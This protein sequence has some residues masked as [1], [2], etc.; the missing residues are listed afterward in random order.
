MLQTSFPRTK[1]IQS[2]ATR[3]TP[4]LLLAVGFE[5]G[6]VQ[7]ITPA[8][9]ACLFV[10][11]AH[12]APVRAVLLVPEDGLV[13]GEGVANTGFSLVTGSADGLVKVWRGEP[14][15]VTVCQ[16]HSAQVRC[17]CEL[18]AGVFASGGLDGWVRVWTALTG[19]LL[20]GVS[21]RGGVRAIAFS[22]P[23]MMACCVD[24]AVV[25]LD[26][27]N[28]DTFAFRTSWIVARAHEQDATS[29]DFSPCSRFVCSAGMDRECKIWSAAGGE[30]LYAVPTGHSAGISA[31]VWANRCSHRIT[32]SSFDRS[33]RTTAVTRSIDRRWRASVSV[34]DNR[35]QEDC[36]KLLWTRVRGVMA[37]DSWL[38]G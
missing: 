7:L 30:L 13:L 19:S 16:G 15:G 21:L 9:G 38:F 18:G 8:T 12:S 2:L 32:T 34:V 3:A 17:L 29:V 31:V 28:P 5:D 37:R 27:V 10:S 20:S 36:L 35:D 1:L 33:V 23:R 11:L 4:S 22:S 14:L 6:E 25:L 24:E 26:L